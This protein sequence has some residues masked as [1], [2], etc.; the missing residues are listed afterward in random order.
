MA[1]QNDRIDPLSFV[2][3]SIGMFLGATTSAVLIEWCGMVWLWPEEGARHALQMV[4]DEAAYLNND[5]V[6]AVLFGWSPT[7]AVHYLTELITGGPLT[8]A[9]LNPERY[10]WLTS[11]SASIAVLH[12]YVL[13]AVYICIVCLIRIVIVLFSLPLYGLFLF[14][15]FFDGLVLRD[16]RKYGGARESGLRHHYAKRMVLPSI[17]CGWGLYLAIPVTIHPNWILVPSVVG[18]SISCWLAVR[19]FKKHL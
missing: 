11:W 1:S 19:Y 7:Q 16:L 18:S 13:A 10:R 2:V 6:D 5:F 3:I 12:D 4:F 15:A 9:T 14:I 17:W 8:E